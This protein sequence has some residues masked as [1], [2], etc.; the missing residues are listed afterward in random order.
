M[1]GAGQHAGELV[2]AQGRRSDH[3]CPAAGEGEYL[4]VVEVLPFVLA[5]AR[6]LTINPCQAWGVG[7]KVHHLI[8]RSQMTR[9]HHRPKLDWRCEMV[10]YLREE[11]SL[12]IDVAVL[13]LSYMLSSDY[14]VREV[15]MEISDSQA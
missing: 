15:R 4:Q 2:H 12:S 11:L 6:H 13:M 9:H 3:M 10:T 1:C 8:Q 14:N 7:R 5:R